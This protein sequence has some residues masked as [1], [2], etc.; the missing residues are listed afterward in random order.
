MHQQLHVIRNTAHRPSTQASYTAS[1]VRPKR[2]IS[3]AAAQIAATLTI[4]FPRWRHT[5]LTSYWGQQRMSLTSYPGIDWGSTGNPLAVWILDRVS[6][7]KYPCNSLHGSDM[8]KEVSYVHI[9]PE[10]LWIN[11]LHRETRNKLIHFKLSSTRMWT[12][13]NQEFARWHK[14]FIRICKTFLILDN[15]LSS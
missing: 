4:S 10:E 12:Q 3:C 5:R 8:G 6:H 13:I 11:L 9:C 2:K 1:R 7:I 14:Q 15:N